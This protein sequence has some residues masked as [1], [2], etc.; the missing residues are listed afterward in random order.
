MFLR[1]ENCDYP[2][3]FGVFH[4][5]CGECEEQRLFGRCKQSSPMTSWWF[6]HVEMV[7]PVARKWSILA[8][9]A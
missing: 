4:T 9:V 3:D 6:F 8:L 7:L 5:A 2:L 1:E